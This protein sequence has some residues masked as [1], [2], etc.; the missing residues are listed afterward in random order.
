MACGIFWGH[1]HHWERWTDR[2]KGDVMRHFNGKE[3]KTGEWVIQQRICLLCGQVQLRTE[4]TQI[5]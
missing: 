5:T 2:S 1:G 3:E 4:R